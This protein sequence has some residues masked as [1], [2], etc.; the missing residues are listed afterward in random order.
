[1]SL[2]LQC[3]NLFFA[4]LL[5]SRFDRVSTVGILLLP[6]PPALFLSTPSRPFLLLPPL[7]PSPSLHHPTGL[8]PN[9]LLQHVL[10]AKQILKNWR[11]SYSYLRAE[12]SLNKS[13][14]A[15]SSSSSSSAVSLSPPSSCIAS[16]CSPV[17]HL[18][19]AYRRWRAHDREKIRTRPGVEVS[20]DTRLRAIVEAAG[21]VAE[22]LGRFCKR[23]FACLC[24]CVGGACDKM[25]PLIFSLRARHTLLLRCHLLSF[26]FE[27]DT[28]FSFTPTPC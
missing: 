26:L 22:A 20:L 28:P 14:P 25:S 11:D 6:F 23:V 8:S 1:M 3:P 17:K 4:T 18:Y 24:V 9:A 7:S 19:A 10:D 15:P 13:Y 12:N 16:T 5:L 27:Q 2:L 21:P